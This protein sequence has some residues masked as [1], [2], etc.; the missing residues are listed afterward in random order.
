MSVVR[1]GRLRVKLRKRFL[2]PFSTGSAQPDILAQ[3]DPH[4]WSVSTLFNESR[5]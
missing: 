3:V 5:S 2:T 1:V 4:L